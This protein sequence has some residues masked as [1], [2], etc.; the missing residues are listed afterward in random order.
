[1]RPLREGAGHPGDRGGRAVL[2]DAGAHTGKDGEGAPDR[3]AECGDQLLRDLGNGSAVGEVA[4]LKTARGVLIRAE[5]H[6][7]VMLHRIGEDGRHIVR[8]IIRIRILLGT[9][10]GAV[11]VRDH[12][13]ARIAVR[14]GIHGL[15]LRIVITVGLCP[16]V[17]SS[18]EG[19]GQTL[20]DGHAGAVGHGS[21]SRLGLRLG[22][23]DRVIEPGVVL[24]KAVAVAVLGLG[25]VIGHA[26][27]DVGR[28]LGRT[29]G[30]RGVFGIPVGIQPKEIDRVIQTGLHIQGI[31]VGCRVRG[32]FRLS[33]HGGERDK[34][35]SR[36]DHR[37]QKKHGKQA[38]FHKF[39]PLIEKIYFDLRD[40]NKNLGGP[41]SDRYN[42]IV[43]YFNTPGAD[44]SIGNRPQTPRFLWLFCLFQVEIFLAFLC[45]LLNLFSR[46]ARAASTS[47]VPTPSAAQDTERGGT[48]KASK[49]AARK[50]PRKRSTSKIALKA[51][52]T[53]K[54]RTHL[55]R[56]LY[57]L[58]QNP[59]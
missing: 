26:V 48:R 10:G 13:V 5:G 1:M 42:N 37:N 43:I 14:G 19:V 36:H 25:E 40:A 38:L 9:K 3:A 6:I 28:V 2:R 50:K 57:V 56:I 27:V 53:R 59:Q 35:Q 4:D 49:G 21:N 8:G 11:G 30:D 54:P 34:R 41:Q 24:H 46:L 31:V 20:N 23:I 58:T 51:A 18:K 32:L 7:A 29:D 15:E 12:L 55:Q 16:L 52:P 22:D 47:C 39:S 17:V 33:G 44:L 45:V